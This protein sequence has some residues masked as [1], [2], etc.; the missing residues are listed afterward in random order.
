[1]ISVLSLKIHP[2]EYIISEESFIT[3]YDKPNIKILHYA[4]T[5]PII[6]ENLFISHNSVYLTLL[7]TIAINKNNS[8]FNL[9]IITDN[10]NNKNY[11]YFT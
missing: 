1:M 2:L 5:R 11:I 10:N 7:L 8:R 3:K 6:P 9:I 4:V